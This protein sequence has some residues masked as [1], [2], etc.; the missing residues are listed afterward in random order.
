MPRTCVEHPIAVM[1]VVIGVC[2]IGY[3]A[4][5]ALPVELM[6]NISYKKITI[7]IGVRGGL[8][9]D[10]NEAT[11][12]K[13]VEDA[14][15]SINNLESIIS[16][17]EKDRAIIVLRF[18][19]GTNMDFA[20]ME[21]REAF[22]KVKNKLPKE[23]EKP[24]ISR[25]EESDAPITILAVT[26]IG[27][28]HSPEEIRTL[29][30]R[31]IKETL[32]RVPGVANIDVSGGREEKVICNINKKSIE[33]NKIPIRKIVSKI[34][35]NT[36]NIRVGAREE[37]SF[38][39]G[40]ILKSEFE[41]VDDI[42][43][44]SILTS[45][46]TGTQ[47]LLK[48]IGSA[49][50]DYMDAQNISRYTHFKGN[51]K[52]GETNNIVS[53][54]IQKESTGNTV[55]ISQG[56]KE[57]LA[58]IESALSVTHPDLRILKVSDQ[59]EMILEAIRSVM[60]SLSS[61]A[62]W[63]FLV[64][65]IFLRRIFI[66]VMVG[67]SMPVSILGT[68]IVMYQFDIPVNVMTLQGLTV[69]VGNILD[70]SICV[71]D[72]IISKREKG[73]SVKESAI[74]GSE[75]LFQEI[76]AS[77]L[78]TMIVF[79]PIFFLTEQLRM[80]YQGLAITV[81]V[82]LVYSFICAFSI[83][84]IMCTKIPLKSTAG[85]PG[86]IRHWGRDFYIKLL[87]F[88]IRYRTVLFGMM[89][90][91][92]WGSYITGKGLKQELTGSGEPIRF[93]IFVELPDGAK[94][95]VSDK[96][97]QEI[98][99]LLKDKQKYPEVTSVT[100]RVEGWSSKVY[101]EVVPKE[102][103]NRLTKAIID[104]LRKAI[105][106]LPE[107]K[108]SDGFVYFTEEAEGG[109]EEVSLDVYGYNYDV[110]RK[111]ANECAGKLE[112]IHGVVDAKLRTTEGRPEFR[113]VPRKDK[114]SEY[115]LTVQEI[116]ETL[117]CMIRGLRASVFHPKD[118]SGTEIETIVRLDPKYVQSL[119]D[120]QNLMIMSPK[121]Q[122][123]H[124]RDVTDFKE[125]LSPSEIWRTNK[126]RMIGVSATTTKL[127]LGEAIEAAKIKLQGVKFPKDYYYVFSGAYYKMLENRRQLIWALI[128]TICLVYMIMAATFENYIFPMLIM[129][130]LPMAMIGVVFGL[131]W[132][133][134]PITMGVF[135]GGIVLAGV[136][137]NGGILLI[138]LIEEMRRHKHYSLYHAT[139]ASILSRTRPLMMTS[140]TTIFGILPMAIDKSQA[141]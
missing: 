110:L 46:S 42:E 87:C 115:G 121:G 68:F 92:L 104:D 71:L 26:S 135:L 1:M 107:I 101:V 105:P 91:L 81:V 118:G 112:E 58:K 86:K 23:T 127:N 12:V 43:N 18:I 37:E 40:I 117:H 83:L 48:D 103:R 72:N 66:S 67:I 11:V 78:S 14:V 93:T 53:L 137:V 47:I 131:K 129:S 122:L 24:I 138:T 28:K 76:L 13:P 95:E 100:S 114:A 16:T 141:A 123:I 80:L 73:Y 102:K 19:P 90:I 132:F 27:E 56:I 52:E 49:K 82:S 98:E 61:G 59:S 70:S 97:I 79:L 140:M 116:A 54:Y 106:T 51:K 6:P 15:G 89:C 75:E 109:G 85:I 64:L 22:S 45:D 38:K 9:P 133:H 124:L 119:N 125:G 25:Y 96:V 50:M 35:V 20:S 7:V 88:S 136:V 120:V 21:V 10:E 94:L 65:L 4:L 77:V 41:S 17:A 34:G 39:K 8:P 2:F 134:R 130:T 55:K 62:Y 126:S 31:K 33:S 108:K 57:T 139:I 84:P 128:V 36:M 99:L 29:V 69:G 113:V 32:M 74:T 60:N 5:L 111:L 63:A 44:T 3:M 30:D